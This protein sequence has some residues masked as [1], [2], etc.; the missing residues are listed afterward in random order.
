VKLFS[1]EEG[2]FSLIPSSFNVEVCLARAVWTSSYECSEMTTSI[3][4]VEAEGC[5]DVDAQPLV[6]SSTSAA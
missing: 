2:S 5:V 4:N 6:V 1:E 3:E